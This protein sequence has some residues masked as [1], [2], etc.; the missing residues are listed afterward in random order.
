MKDLLTLLFEHNA[1]FPVLG[2]V[3]VIIFAILNTIRKSN[4]GSNIDE[5][6]ILGNKLS[7]KGKKDKDAPKKE[8]IDSVE[9]TSKE[10]D[11]KIYYTIIHTI[12]NQTINEAAERADI[13]ERYVAKEKLFIKDQLALVI[14]QIVLDY[15][16]VVDKDKD[17]DV[18]LFQKSFE[19]D[20]K[21][22]IMDKVDVHI[23]QNLNAKNDDEIKSAVDEICSFAKSAMGVFLMKYNIAHKEE[24]KEIFESHLT[25]INSIIKSSLEMIKISQKEQRKVLDARKELFNKEVDRYIEMAG[26]TDSEDWWPDEPNS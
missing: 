25:D 16:K 23:S 18:N 12:I 26:L 15:Y 10:I 7:F 14:N 19:A 8:V 3:A 13:K 4:L 21:R 9:N 20:M 11:K 2:L 22:T 6:S 5:I 17:P 1:F 24:A